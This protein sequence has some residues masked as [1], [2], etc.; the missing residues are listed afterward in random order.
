M[1]N[2]GFRGDDFSTPVIFDFS[3]RR[4]PGSVMRWDRLHP[5]FDWE[6]EDVLARYYHRRLQQILNE[7]NVFSCQSFSLVEVN[8]GKE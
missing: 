8:S 6:N 4:V 3:D 5:G 7:L 1:G 2:W